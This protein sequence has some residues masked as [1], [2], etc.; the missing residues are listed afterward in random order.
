[1]EE[2]RAQQLLYRGA[3]SVGNPTG[4]WFS[5]PFDLSVKGVANTGVLH[6]AGKLLALYEVR[7]FGGEGGTAS[8]SSC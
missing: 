7:P 1:V 5:N 8:L 6:W 2:Q 3:F 4:G